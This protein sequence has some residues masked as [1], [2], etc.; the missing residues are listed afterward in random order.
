VKVAA[1]VEAGTARLEVTNSGSLLDQEA[2][3]SATR[4]FWRGETARTEAGLRCGLGLALVERAALAL[5]GRLVL[6]STRGGDF[7]A[8]VLVPGAT[9]AGSSAGPE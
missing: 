6:T 3:H 4:R 2:T 5:G 1:A 8:A 9:T 7:R